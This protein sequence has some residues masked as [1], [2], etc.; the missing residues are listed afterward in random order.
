MY[1]TQAFELPPD[2]Q[3][4]LEKAKKLEWITLFY[5]LSVVVVMYV[6][7]GNSQAMKAAWLED[8]L[9]IL[10]SIAFLTATKIYD[11]EATNRFP[12]GYHRV[13][14]IAYLSGAFALFGMGCFLLI[15]S[16]M[17]LL[18][19][20][21]P[22]IGSMKLFGRQ[23][24]MGWVMIAALLYSSLPAMLLGFK[25]L[26]HAKALHNKI[27]YTDAEAQKADYMT[28]F[29]AILGIIGVG[30]GLWW[31]DAVA[32]LFISFSVL[33]DGFTQLKTAILDLMDR[34]PVHIESREKDELVREVE[35]LVR[36]WPWVDEAKVRLR[37]HGQIYF[38]EVFVI[39]RPNANI[40]TEIE[41][42]VQALLDYHWKIHDI[43][44]TPVATLDE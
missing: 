32:A 24:W 10:P 34:H 2:L 22:T 3:E 12:Y 1:L 23:I 13:F 38:G 14:S 8:T 11:K 31:A 15:D 27:L 20:E 17:T 9:S 43:V 4:R 36:S 33:H 16:S 19:A 40:V 6:V 41:D 35:N 30:F 5:L 29:A 44:I 42:G 25:K 37:E 21:H 39:P 28:A 18:Y 7:L 26:P